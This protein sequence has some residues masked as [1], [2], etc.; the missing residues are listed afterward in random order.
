MYFAHNK[1]PGNHPQG[2]IH[3]HAISYKKNSLILSPVSS[4]H[5]RVNCTCLCLDFS[6]CPNASTNAWASC[7]SCILIS[8]R[9]LFVATHIA[10]T[11]FITILVRVTATPYPYPVKTPLCTVR[12][13]APHT[14]R[15][16][17]DARPVAQSNNLYHQLHA[18]WSGRIHL[19]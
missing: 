12:P 18:S 5:V 13:P 17:A 19:S 11:L 15:I 14:K 7:L 9:K 8:F 6:A 16:P 1:S 2:L 10:P 3:L 4:V